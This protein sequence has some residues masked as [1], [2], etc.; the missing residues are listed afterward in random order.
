[1]NKPKLWILFFLISYPAVFAILYSPAF[2]LLST[3]F[4]MDKEIVQLTLSIYLLG[5]AIGALPY[6]PIANSMGRKKTLV[7]GNTIAIVGTILCLVAI[8]LHSFYLLVLGRFITALG[9]SVG[10][11]IAFT[12][13]GDCFSV[14]ESR[15]VIPIIALS[16]PL[17]PALLMPLCGFLTEFFG[18]QSCFYFMLLYSLF[19]LTIGY[20]LKETLLQKDRVEIHIKSTIKHYIYPFKTPAFV[21]STLIYGMGISFF[22]LFPLEAPFIAIQK[23]GIS[24]ESYGVLSF[25]PYV[26]MTIGLLLSIWISGKQKS[27]NT[28]FIGTLIITFFSLLMFFCFLFNFVNIWTLFAFIPFTL[29][30]MGLT[31]TNASSIAMSLLPDKS[32]TSAVMNSLAIA[33]SAACVFIFQAIPSQLLFALP[34]FFVVLGFLMITSYLIIKKS[35]KLV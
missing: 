18:F 34:L 23:I 15:K 19:I 5:Y 22:Y 26:G 29:L 31:Y 16:F 10:L 3:Y 14:S 8:E 33:T 32:N 27:L 9:A 1:M 24:P 21:F 6:G 7:L 4:G 28:L 17:L 11:K 12:L 13:V 2:P 30:G 25:I 20:C 35:C